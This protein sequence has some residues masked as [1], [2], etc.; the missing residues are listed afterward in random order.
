MRTSNQFLGQNLLIAML[1]V[2]A[3]GC[4]NQPE[5]P[6]LADASGT[7]TLDGR[8]LPRGVVQLIPDGS[9]GTEGPVGTGEI[10]GNGQFT[11]STLGVRGAIVGH[12]R[13]RVISTEVPTSERPDPPSIIPNKYNLAHRSGLTAEVKG[14]RSNTIDLQL[15]SQP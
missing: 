5:L 7:V 1:A 8:P 11:I 14:N 4:K 3:V 2:G 6:P 9:K 12:H 10:E 15:S 13:I